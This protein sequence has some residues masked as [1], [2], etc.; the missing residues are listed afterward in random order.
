MNRE[1]KF[2]GKSLEHNKWFYGYLEEVVLCESKKFYIIQFS[3]WGLNLKF[4]V[5]EKSIGQYTG[6]KDKNEK[7]IY[8]DDILD[9]KVNKKIEWTRTVE[10]EKDYCAFILRGKKHK[11][12]VP[13]FDVHYLQEC[14]IIGNTKELKNESNSDN[15][16]MED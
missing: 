7:E 11:S 5:D 1:I 12:I 16:S 8:Q 13:L 9:N 15:K 4:E 10:W 2:R 6:L 14:E 3:D